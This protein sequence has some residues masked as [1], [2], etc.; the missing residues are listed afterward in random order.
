V[1]VRRYSF[2]W[3]PDKARSNLAKHG[4]SFENALRVFYDPFL[5]TRPDLR[6][7][8]RSISLGAVEQQL[9]VVVH[10]DVETTIEPHELRIRIR[11]ISARR[12]T[13]RC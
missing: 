4:V 1:G 11:I 9:L 6:R 2:D 13:G 7:R 5:L 12:A 8:N 10:T 3:D